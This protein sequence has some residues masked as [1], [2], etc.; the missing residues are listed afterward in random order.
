MTTSLHFQKLLCRFGVV[1][2]MFGIQKRITLMCFRALSEK[3][4]L[5]SGGDISDN[6]G[7]LWNSCC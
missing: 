3:F 2:V 7:A 5:F 1:R 4:S 6:W